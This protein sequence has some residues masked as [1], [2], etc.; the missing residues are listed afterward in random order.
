MRIP[1]ARI[2]ASERR[3]PFVR[4]AARIRPFTAWKQAGAPVEKHAAI[5]RP[6]GLSRDAG[7]GCFVVPMTTSKMGKWRE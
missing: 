2:N 6:A 1:Q 5:E 4:N 7:R 3:K